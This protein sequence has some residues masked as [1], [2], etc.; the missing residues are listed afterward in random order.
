MPNN[1]LVMIYG[2]TISRRIRKVYQV[3][4][5]NVIDSAVFAY[6]KN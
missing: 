5:V 1:M 4:S 6:H 2:F 3:I